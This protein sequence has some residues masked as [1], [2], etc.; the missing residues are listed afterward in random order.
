MKA[1]LDTILESEAQLEQTKRLTYE[2]NN[3]ILKII[4]ISAT[5][6]KRPG[7][8]MKGSKSPDLYMQLKVGK[9]VKQTKPHIA[10]GKTPFWN[11]TFEFHRTTEMYVQ[12]YVFDND[13][14][15]SDK[16]IGKAVFKIRRAVSLNHDP[17]Q[18]EPKFQDLGVDL[19]DEN[20]KIVGT[21]SLRL[22]I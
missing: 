18:G 7:S 21:A 20:K 17:D 19:I 3:G 12:I 22:S 15:V 4:A 13:L 5:L 6:K 16:V 2:R 14:Y 11:E 10:A 1:K 8:G 9:Q